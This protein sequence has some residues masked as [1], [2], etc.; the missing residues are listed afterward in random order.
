VRRLSFD[1]Y[2][3]RVADSTTRAQIGPNVWGAD[4]PSTSTFLDLFSCR[5]F[6]PHSADNG[7]VSQ[8]CDPRTDDLMRQ[9]TALQPTDPRAADALWAR[10]ERRVLAAVPAIPVLN[11]VHTDLVSTRVR[12][13]QYHPQW[14]LLLDQVSVR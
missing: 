2:F 13:D 6:V 7:N 3:A 5:S 9:A 14:G 4:Y 12:N 1:S 11:P 8:F 10:A